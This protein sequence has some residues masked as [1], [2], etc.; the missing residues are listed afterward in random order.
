MMCTILNNYQFDTFDSIGQLSPFNNFPDN[1]EFPLSYYPQYLALLEQMEDKCCNQ[2]FVAVKQDHKLRAFILFQQAIFKGKEALSFL[3][4]EKEKG[5]TSCFKQ[6]LSN[7]VIGKVSDMELDLAVSGNLFF[8]GDNGFYFDKNVTAQEK[9]EI[10][11]ELV[12]YL[13]EELKSNQKI[14]AIIFM[15]FYQEE[16]AF[17]FLET[18]NFSVFPTEPDLFMKIEANWLVFSDYLA[19]ISSKYRVKYNKVKNQNGDLEIKSL[20]ANDIIENEAIIWQ[21]YKNV[22]ENASFNLGIL[23]KDYFSILKANLGEKFV[24]EGYF[25]EDK[26]VGFTSMFMD[27]NYLEDHYIGLDY[28]INAQFQV[29]HRMLYEYVRFAIDNRLSSIHYGRTATEIKTTIGAYPKEMKAYLCHQSKLANY[30]IQPLTKNVVA[31]K[32]TIRNPFKKVGLP[33]LEKG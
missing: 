24:V 30:F 27:K 1:F 9:R 2:L 12:D 33:E 13:K 15:D 31:K 7:L 28:E 23:P 11:A 20:N 21:L 8:S 29:Y 4:T 10:I 16:T 5:I 19:A 26:L 14:K 17:D 25:L 18:K 22:A 32:Y 6:M 3:P